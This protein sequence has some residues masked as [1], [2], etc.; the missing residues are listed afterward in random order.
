MRLTSKICEDQQLEVDEDLHAMYT[1]T[2]YT[3]VT[4][5]GDPALS[6]YGN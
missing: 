5:S 2:A 3:S 6:C 4:K 1:S